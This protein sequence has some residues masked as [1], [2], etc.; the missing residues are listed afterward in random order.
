MYAA[1]L[2]VYGI[3]REQSETDAKRFRVGTVGYDSFHDDEF[4][5]NF[6]HVTTEPFWP[7][8]NAGGWILNPIND[9]NLDPSSMTQ[10]QIMSVS[11]I[12]NCCRMSLRQG[13]KQSA[14]AI[15]IAVAASATAGNA[16]VSVAQIQSKL[17]G[18]GKSMSNI[19]DLAKRLEIYGVAERRLACVSGRSTYQIKLRCSLYHLDHFHGGAA[20]RIRSAMEAHYA[21]RQLA[22]PLAVLLLIAIH[23]YQIQ[24]SR[25]LGR[26][27][28]PEF[29]VHNSP[30]SP[31]R[32]LHQL[33]EQG[34]ITIIRADRHSAR[35]YLVLPVGGR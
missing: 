31:T 2:N 32:I 9:L 23:A 29:A 21:T 10:P 24:D 33:H 15:R 25:A 30:S 34:L 28:T 8:V 12:E 4:I 14:L 3:G 17:E 6:Q 18:V 35:P 1:R 7:A 11:E 5:R 22:T 26:F 13:P 27:L 19:R 20:E 16:W